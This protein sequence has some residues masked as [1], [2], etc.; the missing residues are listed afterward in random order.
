M[1]GPKMQSGP[2]YRTH[3]HGQGKW[4]GVGWRRRSIFG[5][6]GLR[7]PLSDITDAEAELI[8]RHAQGAPRIAEIGVFEGAT[9]AALGTIATR[10]LVLID[11]YPAGRLF[12]RNMAHTVAART[13]GEK[14]SVPVRWVRLESDRAAQGWRD[15]IDFLRVD[16][17]HTLEG[18][19]RDW[20]DWSRFVPAGGHVAVRADVVS[21]AVGAEDEFA[22]GDEIVPWILDR[23]PGWALVERIETTAVLR[24]SA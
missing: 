4:E 8:L 24:R 5:A 6:L 16:G 2:I 7:P 12:G 22:V 19:Q 10:E 21:E 11:P 9:A 1:P 17:I 20:Q 15:P 18:V 3:S 14:V 23:A 13:V